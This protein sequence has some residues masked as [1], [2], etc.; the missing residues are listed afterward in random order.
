MS[1]T[2]LS[3]AVAVVALV[4]AIGGGQAAAQGTTT[5]GKGCMFHPKDGGDPVP[6][7]NGETYTPPVQGSPERWRLTTKWQCQNGKLVKTE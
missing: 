3:V 4:L 2:R 1:A 7:A 6:V 5:S